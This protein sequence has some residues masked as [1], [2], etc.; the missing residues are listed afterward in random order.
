MACSRVKFTF[1]LFERELINND[2]YF[3]NFDGLL[4]TGKE[5]HAEKIRDSLLDRISLGS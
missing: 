2:V 1:H 3:V 4:R 5:L